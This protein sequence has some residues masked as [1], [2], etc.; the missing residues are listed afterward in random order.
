MKRILSIAAKLN[1]SG[2]E[3][4]SADI[5]FYAHQNMMKLYEIIS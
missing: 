4:V 3:K 1:T 2:A 5:G